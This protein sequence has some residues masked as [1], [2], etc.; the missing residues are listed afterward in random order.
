VDIVVVLDLYLD[1][2]LVQLRHLVGERRCG[3]TF[4]VEE[5]EVMER[6][7]IAERDHPRGLP[8]LAL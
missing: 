5:T 2:T 1:L 3:G 4:L 6:P 7:R 8:K